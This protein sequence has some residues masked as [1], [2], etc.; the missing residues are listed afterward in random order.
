MEITDLV[1]QN[2]SG[3]LGTAE[4]QR[5][6]PNDPPENL[7]VENLSTLTDQ[8]FTFTTPMVFTHDQQLQLA[9]NCSGNQTACDVDLYF[10]GPLTEP[11][12][13]TTTTIP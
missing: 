1:V 13:D 9:V 11:V 2:V 10:V 6:T 5:V 4:V 12:T 8:E 7:L 3:S